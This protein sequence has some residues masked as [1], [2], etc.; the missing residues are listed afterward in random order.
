MA[1]LEGQSIA[2][3][4][5]QLLHVDTEGG[6]A[7]TTLVPIKDGNNDTT[8]CL[9]LATTSA[10]IV[11]DAK[12]YFGTGSDASI[13][14]DEDGADNLPIAG[15]DVSIADGIGLIVGNTAQVAMGEVTSEVQILGTSETDACLAIGLS[16]TT[17]AL[18]PSLKFVKQAHGTIGN[19]SV[20][21]A[22][23]EELGK[24]QA[25]GSDTADSDTLSSEIAFNIDDDGVGAG[26]LGG[27]IQLKTSGK[28]GT[29]D[30]AVTIDSSQTVALVGTLNLADAEESSPAAGDIWFADGQFHLASDWSLL[31]G[32][33]ST[34]ANLGTAR[35]WSASTGTVNAGLITGGYVATEINTTE[36]YNGIAWSAGGNLTDPAR[37]TFGAC[38][39]LTAAL[40]AGGD[41]GGT[42]VHAE[43][44]DGTSW[45]GVADMSQTRRAPALAGTQTAGLAAG[46][47]T[48]A[49]LSI[50]EE[51]DGTSWSVGGA[52]GTAQDAHT[53]AGTQTAALSVCGG[54]PNTTVSDVV[55]EY[56]GSS[57]SNG[58]SVNTARRQLGAGGTASA[59]LCFGGDTGVSS[60]AYS[61]VAEEYDGTAWTTVGSIS[62]ARDGISGGGTQS[63]GWCTAGDTGSVSNITEHYDKPSVVAHHL[64]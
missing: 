62:T 43:E 2:A 48:A 41:S 60:T 19:H 13:E 52:M 64:V 28:D 4:Y 34:H 26:T 35:Q 31:V 32:V 61:A 29:L 51:Y 23:D 22:D 20:T 15:S 24:I 11:D 53:G 18:S 47:S 3:S 33:W 45:A 1:K 14:Y 39:T 55:Q 9:Q 7:T 63:A 21:V 17:N 44:Y 5:D 50:T 25:Y 36:E 30:T 42:H 46:G 40:C 56:D 16:H 10:L 57:W 38:G 27:E 8:F 49:P 54:V 37:S 6:G 59:A 58:G 12:L